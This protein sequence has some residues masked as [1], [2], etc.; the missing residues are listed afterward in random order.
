MFHY[1]SHFICGITYCMVLLLTVHNQVFCAVQY[2]DVSN[3]LQTILRR[4]DM[5]IWDRTGV[6]E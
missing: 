4:D 1:L 2:F 3:K 5:Y 6:V